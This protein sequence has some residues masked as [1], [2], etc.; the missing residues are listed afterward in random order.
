[1]LQQEP[2]QG[3]I[4]V[5]H[6]HIQRR[7]APN[8]A[9]HIERPFEPH[10]QFHSQVVT[11]L[12]SG[13]FCACKHGSL[14]VLNGSFQS[15]SVARARSAASNI[16]RFGPHRASLVI[17]DVILT[18]PVPVVQ[19]DTGVADTIPMGAVVEFSDN[20][21]NFFVEVDWQ[22][23]RFSLFREDLLEACTWEDVERIGFGDLVC[24][25]PTSKS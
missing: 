2:D 15:S 5:K 10:D 11:Q 13:P 22:G 24:N 9:A 8:S 1:M 19:R 12:G 16:A 18:K 23:H 17:V 21:R 3:H 7:A 6:S 4:A 25:F 14:E 20:P